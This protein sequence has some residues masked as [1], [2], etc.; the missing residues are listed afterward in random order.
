[1]IGAKVIASDLAAR[2]AGNMSMWHFHFY[3]LRRRGILKTLEG[4]RYK[5]TAE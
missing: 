4:L 1:M 5:V 2:E 3:K